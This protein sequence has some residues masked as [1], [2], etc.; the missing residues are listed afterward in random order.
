MCSLLILFFLFLLWFFQFLNFFFLTSFNVF[1]NNYQFY[2]YP[3]FLHSKIN[4]IL[5]SNY[6]LFPRDTIT[7][8]HNEV[9]IIWIKINF[10]SYYFINLLQINC[11]ILSLLNLLDLII[12]IILIFITT[13][14]PNLPIFFIPLFITLNF[15]FFSF[16][17]LNLLF[18]YPIHNKRVL[19]YY[20]LPQFINNFLISILPILTVLTKENHHFHR[21]HLVVVVI[22]VN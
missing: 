13:I 22:V 19:H 1:T 3:F 2:F 5:G 18:I 8:I 9:I 11:P 14:L 4:S 16:F 20:F 10:Y 17:L 12:I 6:F 7:Y 15:L 21:N